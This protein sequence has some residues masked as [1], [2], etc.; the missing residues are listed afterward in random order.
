MKPKDLGRLEG[1]LHA[2]VNHQKLNSYCAKEMN[3]SQKKASQ[4]VE[5]LYDLVK[6]HNEKLENKVFKDTCNVCGEPS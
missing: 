6:M 2:L 1:L 4:E 5:D 3:M